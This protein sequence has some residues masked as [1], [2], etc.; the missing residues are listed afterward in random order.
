ML[1]P[2]WQSDN[3]QLDSILFK[4]RKRHEKTNK[5]S[6]TFADQAAL[7]YQGLLRPVF[8]LWIQIEVVF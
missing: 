7:D 2:T 1:D 5:N 4:A 8:I 6:Q 3:I